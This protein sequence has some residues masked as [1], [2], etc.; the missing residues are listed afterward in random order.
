MPEPPNLRLDE[1]DFLKKYTELNKQRT[2]H[3]LMVQD[4][5]DDKEIEKAS[6]VLDSGAMKICK[7]F[8]WWVEC[9]DEI[10]S[11]NRSHHGNKNGHPLSS[12][13][14]NY[15]WLNQMNTPLKDA[16]QEIADILA[17]EKAR[18]WQLE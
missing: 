13:S 2:Y 7:M 11:S 16:D 3:I 8:G 1:L 5:E 12:D 18:Q 17:S 14:K 10:T 6:W 15:M 9:T 4:V